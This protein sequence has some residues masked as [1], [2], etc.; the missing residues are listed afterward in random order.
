[1]RYKYEESIHSLLTG[2]LGISVFRAALRFLRFR[3]IDSI[4]S[5]NQIKIFPFYW[6]QYT[7]YLRHYN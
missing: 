4:I 6:F 2:A 5:R 3:Y 7:K 1:M